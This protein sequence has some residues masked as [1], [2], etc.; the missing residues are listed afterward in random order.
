MKINVLAENLNR[1]LSVVGRSVTS[2]GQLPILANVLIKGM[3]NG[4]ELCST[5]LEM[6]FR[7]RVGA[8]VLEEGEI[9]IPAKILTELAGTIS[10]GV[11]ELST[12]EEKLT[13][14]AGK[15]KAELQGMNASEFP[16]IP[17]F[18][19]EAQ[20]VVEREE[21]VKKVEEIGF[22]AARDESRPILTGVWW[23]VKDGSVKLAATDGYRLSVGALKTKKMADV[24]EMVLPA[25]ALGELVKVVAKDEE[26]E[27]KIRVEKEKQQVIFACGEVELVSRLLSGDFPPFDQ[28]VPKT[29]LTRVRFEVEEFSELVRRA[30]IFAR[31]S[32]N[33]I[34][35]GVG[36]KELSVSANSPQVG[37]NQGSMEVEV[38][39]EAMEVAFNSRYLL[40]Y[41][42]VV[43]VKEL[44]FESGGGLKPGVFKENGDDWVHVIMP[45]RVAE[46]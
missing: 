23:G 10:S 11:V 40:E 28:V 35:V 6:S 5:D 2:R 7:V 20:I 13:L 8:K 25:R 21:L 18:E 41:L 29:H 24:D 4:M 1:A 12:E 19:G 43:K 45:V 26:G 37:S 34:K 16:S 44:V 9:T 27:V 36:E 32:A 3:K 14:V 30:A 39:G 15:T 38:E 42:G 46:E 22:A 31:E 33:I 17:A